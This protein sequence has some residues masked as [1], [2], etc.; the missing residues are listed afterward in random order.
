MESVENA[1]DGRSLAMVSV[2]NVHDLIDKLVLN[3]FEAMRTGP[4]NYPNGDAIANNIGSIYRE[5]VAAIDHLIGIDHIKEDQLLMIKTLSESYDKSS[6][7]VTRLESELI[8]L[9][10]LIDLK[11]NETM[12][13][14]EGNERGN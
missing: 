2:D 5:T 11:L 14:L 7:N 3:I 4:E 9:Q 12:Q 1:S 8:Q 10:S 13:K 6:Q